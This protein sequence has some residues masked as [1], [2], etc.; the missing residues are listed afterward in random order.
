MIR[1]GG[2][3]SVAENI[4]PGSSIFNDRQNLNNEI[5]ILKSFRLNKR[6]IDSLPEF[7]IVYFG[8]G[9]RNIVES[10]LYK[11]CPFIVIYEITAILSQEV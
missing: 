2:A 8:V 4:M 3:S 1:I 6:V 11:N 9:R 7:R 5:G 10:R